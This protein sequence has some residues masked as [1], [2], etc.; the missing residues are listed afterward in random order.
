[1]KIKYIALGILALVVISGFVLR[2]TNT[3]TAPELYKKAMKINPE[4]AQA[5]AELDFMEENSDAGIGCL[6]ELLK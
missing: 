2:I 3:E 5:C 6:K 1:M 4:Q